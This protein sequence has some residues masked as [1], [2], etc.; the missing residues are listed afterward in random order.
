MTPMPARRGVVLAVLFLLAQSA[1]AFA[2]PSAVGT[3]AATADTRA[4]RLRHG[5]NLT[6][7][8]RPLSD[9]RYTKEHI[10][11]VVTAQ[12]LALIHAMGFDHVRLCINP[13]PLF[14]AEQPEQIPSESLGYLDGALKLILDEG[15]AVDL[16]IQ[17][18]DAFKRQFVDDGF[19]ERFAD[20]W[21][22]L[23]RHYA[24][25]DPDRVFFEVVN[26][27]ELHDRYRWY[28]VETRLVTAIREGAPLHTIIATGAQWS[29]DD[30]LIVFEPLRDANVIYAFHFYQPFLFTHQGATW[31]EYF[32]HYLRGVPYPSRPDA[33]RTAAALVPDPGDR[34]TVVRY[35]M[36]QWNAARVEVEIG[37]VAAWA[38]RWK[39]PVICNEFGVY[40]LNADP[41]ERVAWI[42]DVRTSL[43]RHGIGWAV[44]EYSGGF[45]LATKQ[46]GV[47]SVDAAAARALG[48]TI[49]PSSENFIETK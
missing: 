20:F 29:D 19:V 28:G 22:A 41:A 4:A 36:S 25:L 3:V 7:W 12:D 1:T 45:G 32:W 26:E 2:Q 37:Q 46:N 24:S 8:F 5:V 10:D 44:W 6:D 30:D 49:P 43:D 9:G 34:L 23:A 35:G 18:D 47:L 14:R 40:A 31:S 48:R 21:R 13:R 11:T 17:P 39:V 38:A 27:P 42:T 15:L 33:A 16:D